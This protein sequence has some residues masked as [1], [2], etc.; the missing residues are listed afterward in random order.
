M[1][2]D[3]GDSR[4][5]PSLFAQMEGPHGSL[6]IAGETGVPA[7]R[8]WSESGVKAEIEV[9]VV[10]QALHI[11]PA[12]L[13]PHDDAPWF[14]RQRLALGK[15][16]QTV[17]RHLHIAVVGL[18][19]TGSV[20][21]VQLAHLGVGRITVIDGDRVELSNV[22]R[23]LGATCRDAGVTSKVDVAARYAE[24]LGLGT[25]IDVAR[26]HLGTDVSTA[27]IESCDVVLSCVDRHTPRA[28]LNRFAY[29]KAV[30]R[31]IQYQVGT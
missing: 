6:V 11:L 7:G 28:L 16:G 25:R 21:L 27:E 12:A 5:I 1:A 18:G 20:V 10:G 13:T 17:L 30:P 31:P 4:L 19:G 24:Q 3:D 14:E 29:E 23:I 26:G 2:D 15:R 22:S 9:R 8:V